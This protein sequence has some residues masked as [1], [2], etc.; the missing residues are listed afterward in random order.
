VKLDGDRLVIAMVPS[1][2][3]KGLTR[4]GDIIVGQMAAIML[5]H[6]EVTKW[7]I[8]LA[9]PKQPDAQRL[10]QLIKERLAKAGVTNA[11]VLGAAGPAKI[12]GVVQER[13]EDGVAPVCPA[14]KE[15]KPRPELVTP[16]ATMKQRS[17]SV[18]P[19]AAEPKAEPAK[20]D[21]ELEIEV[22]N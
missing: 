17:G 7:L 6:N 22:G 11:D 18:P 9:Q 15:V 20:K 16:K 2:D 12:G 13:A 3:R 19:P 10:A 21:D 14:G 8:A 5:A 4:A 1:M